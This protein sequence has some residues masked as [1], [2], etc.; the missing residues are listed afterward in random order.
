MAPPPTTHIDA[1]LAIHTHWHQQPQRTL[2]GAG[3]GIHPGTTNTKRGTRHHTQHHATTHGP[4]TDE[5][6]CRG[7]RTN[8][9]YVTRRTTWRHT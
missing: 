8:T 9:T 2:L 5:H 3:H 1:G 4:A 7:R 6:V